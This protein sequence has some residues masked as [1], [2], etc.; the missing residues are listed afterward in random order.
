MLTNFA[1][2]CKLTNCKSTTQSKQQGWL[3]ANTVNSS[4]VTVRC[5]SA[6]RF[7]DDGGVPIRVN[8]GYVYASTGAASPTKAL[9]TAATHHLSL[10]TMNRTVFKRLIIQRK[11][12]FYT[13]F[14]IGAPA[15]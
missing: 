4:A 7:A 1:S 13:K 6:G 10:K 8:P 14:F 2:T 15:I 3:E 9:V 11:A 5:L 12:T